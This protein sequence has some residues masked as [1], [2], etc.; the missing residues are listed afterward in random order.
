MGWASEFMLGGI[1]VLLMVAIGKL[2]EIKKLLVKR[3]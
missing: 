1:L 3:Q 2:D